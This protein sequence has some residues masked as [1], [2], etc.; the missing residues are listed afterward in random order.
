MLPWKT[1]DVNKVP[2]IKVDGILKT[3]GKRRLYFSRV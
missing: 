1:V 3:M 2:I